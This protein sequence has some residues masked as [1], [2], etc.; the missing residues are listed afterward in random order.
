MAGFASAGRWWLPHRPRNRVSGRLTYDPLTGPG[1]E[2]DRDFDV[3]F[4]E[5]G[6][7]LYDTGLLDPQPIILGTCGPSLPVTLHRCHKTQVSYRRSR[8]PTARFSAETAV[9]GAH[10]ATDGKILFE[11]VSAFSRPS[12]DAWSSR[13]VVIQY[14]GS[15]ALVPQWEPV[16]SNPVLVED[17]HR[18]TVNWSVPLTKDQLLDAAPPAESQARLFIEPLTPAPL[19]DLMRVLRITQNFIALGIG[20]ALWPTS[21][22]G[23][24]QGPVKAA[25]R[26]MLTSADVVLLRRAW[27]TWAEPDTIQ[28]HTFLFGLSDVRD[29]LQQYLGRWFE[30]RENIDLTLNAYYPA[31]YAPN[32]YYIHQFLSWAFALET[33]FR[34][35]DGETELSPEEFAERKRVLM[36]AFPGYSGWID[37]KIYGNNKPLDR[38]IAKL[39]IQFTELYRSKEDRPIKKARINQFADAVGYNRNFYAHGLVDRRHR[40]A[41]PLVINR[42]GKTLRLV[43]ELTLLRHIGV[44]MDLLKRWTSRDNERSRALVLDLTE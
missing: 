26:R 27:P 29:N 34:Q 12:L 14:K 2:L 43:L 13:F 10:L 24:V 15:K 33:Y 37:K 8:L 17:R 5:G 21:L 19:D 35:V 25:G 32:L 41:S 31:L 38:I 7:V 18:L 22:Q 23:V 20:R 9:L 11:S 42:M 40:V 28:P 39:M 16:E 6:K 4:P 36:E 1:L 3:V 44:D 30:E